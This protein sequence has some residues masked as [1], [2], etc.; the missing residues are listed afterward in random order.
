MKPPT[1]GQL[2]LAYLDFVVA[3][4]NQK[5]IPNPSTVTSR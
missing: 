2:P 3:S 5:L 1:L 4:K